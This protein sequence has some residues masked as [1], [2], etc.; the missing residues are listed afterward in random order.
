MQLYNNIDLVQVDIKT[1]VEEYYLPK[2]CGLLKKR[3][4]IQPTDSHI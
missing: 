1:G 2:S 3:R 4:D